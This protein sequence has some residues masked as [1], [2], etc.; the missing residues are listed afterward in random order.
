[1]AAL[2]DT[3]VVAFLLVWFVLLIIAVTWDFYGDQ[4][5]K[6][7]NLPDQISPIECRA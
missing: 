7:L 5:A 1:M 3:A 4:S 6:V 2:A